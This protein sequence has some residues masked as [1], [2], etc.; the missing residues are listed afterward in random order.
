ML[1]TTST[2]ICQVSIIPS[3]ETNPGSAGDTATVLLLYKRTI[4]GRLGS[5]ALV[6]A[7][8]GVIGRSSIS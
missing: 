3:V 2:V 6:S 5:M 8:V 1:S 7:V 4:F